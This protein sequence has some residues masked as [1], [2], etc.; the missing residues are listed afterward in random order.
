VSRLVSNDLAVGFVV[1]NAAPVTFG[2]WCWAIPV[3]KG[4]QAA[5]GFVWFWTILELGN[6]VG[7][8]GLAWSRGGAFLVR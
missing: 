6:G 2:L 8:L 4:W 5:R 1:V 3:R 7:H